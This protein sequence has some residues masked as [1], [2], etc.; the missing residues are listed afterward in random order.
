MGN[1]KNNVSFDFLSS[2]WLTVLGR[3]VLPISQW[4]VQRSY[5]NYLYPYPTRWAAICQNLDIC[6][7]EDI[8]T[9]GQKYLS[10]KKIRPE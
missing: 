10:E 6:V 1:M 2:I 8:L 7:P 5:F 9:I 3:N 4:F